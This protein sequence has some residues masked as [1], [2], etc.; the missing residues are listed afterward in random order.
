MVKP[1]GITIWII[2]AVAIGSAAG[3]RADLRSGKQAYQRADY[4]LAREEL[5]PLAEAGD[6]DAQVYLG[7]MH[8]A[9]KGVDKDQLAA[10]RWYREAAKQGHPDGQFNLG[11]MYA[12]GRGVP[13][14]YAAAVR[15]YTQ[16]AEQGH[17]GA[18][19][20]LG[21]CY[22]RG[23]GV[24][25][26]EETA[27]RWFRE[28]ADQDS[29]AAQF[30]LG[31]M[32]ATGNGEPDPAEAA[33]WYTKAAEQGY[34]PAQLNLGGCYERGLG[35]PKD[36]RAAANWYRLAAASGNKAAKANLARVAVALKESPVEPPVAVAIQEGGVVPVLVESEL[37]AGEGVPM[38][39]PEERFAGDAPL[40]GTGVGKI[41]TRADSVVGEVDTLVD[42]IH[43][44]PPPV[45][46]APTNG[47]QEAAAEDDD[48]GDH[49]RA[50]GVSGTSAV[51][52]LSQDDEMILAWRNRDSLPSPASAGRTGATLQESPAP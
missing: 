38:P 44:S 17:T 50:M 6:A 31:L 34:A 40:E 10:A 19:V 37:P 27:M 15:L 33:A 3:A 42:S 22:S 51:S 14:N 1:N 46:G 26:D 23:Y 52:A 20:N 4:D 12:K 2:V 39:D 18:Q 49:P 11:L 43:D 32:Y 8:A 45:P 25:R 35:V 16:A 5:L 21:V 41:V 47:I 29:A 30:N 9:G 36:P 24:L 48:S 13:T 28:A 7:L